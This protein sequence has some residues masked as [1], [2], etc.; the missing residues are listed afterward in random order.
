MHTQ[1]HGGSPKG[2]NRVS[3]LVQGP[4]SGNERTDWPPGMVTAEDE[5]RFEAYARAAAFF[6]GDQWPDRV[7]AGDPPPLI[8]N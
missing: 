2:E 6:A 1:C 4:W 7:R 8:F 5:T 3:M